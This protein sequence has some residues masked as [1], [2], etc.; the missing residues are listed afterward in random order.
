M[1]PLEQAPRLEA[2]APQ[3][4]HAAHVSLG[5]GHL[6]KGELLVEL[7][8]AGL[9]EGEDLMVEEF[10]VTLCLC[11]L[12]VVSEAPNGGKER[13]RAERTRESLTACLVRSKP[14]K[15]SYSQ[16]WTVCIRISPLLQALAPRPKS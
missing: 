6:P 16:M 4:E 9:N 8:G 5:F 14:G 10:E 7:R 11:V 15:P 2:V 13:P 3:L 12:W 1:F